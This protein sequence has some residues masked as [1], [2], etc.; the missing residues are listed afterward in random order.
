MKNLLKFTFVLIS[1]ITI[2]CVSDDDFAI[3]EITVPVYVEDF[4]TATNNAPVS[5]EGWSTHV[6]AGSVNWTEKTFSSNGTVRFSSFQS[7]EPSNIAWLI[8]PKFEF[9]SNIGKRLIFESAHSFLSN[10][11]NT[12]DVYISTNYDSNV[13]TA[14]WTRITSNF[15]MPQSSDSNFTFVSSGNF[16]LSAIEGPFNIAFKAVGNTSTLTAG[17]EV[18]NFIIY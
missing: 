2:S 11:S 3:P 9:D 16:D 7:G 17:F 8:S 12:F 6:E 18:D 1:L 10:P 4:Q 14:T 13:T 5:F 15:R